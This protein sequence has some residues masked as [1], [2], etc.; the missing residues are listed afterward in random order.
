[1]PWKCVRP[2]SSRISSGR[3][4]RAANGCSIPQ[5]AEQRKIL[6]L[7]GGDQSIRTGGRFLNSKGLLA[8][9]WRRK[10]RH[11]LDFLGTERKKSARTDFKYR[12]FCAQFTVFRSN[13]WN[14]EKTQDLMAVDAGSCEPLSRPK[15]PANREK[16][17]EFREFGQA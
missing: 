5:Q 15:F 2:C 14:R 10:L 16:N 3:R 1:M 7:D 12:D 13:M 4:D 11:V 17:R 8:I 9:G 6:R